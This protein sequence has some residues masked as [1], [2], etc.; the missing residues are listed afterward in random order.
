ME[1]LETHTLLVLKR[2][3]VAADN[4]DSLVIAA[5]ELQLMSSLPR[6][7]NIVHYVDS[8]VRGDE[9]ATSRGNSS[10]FSGHKS[11]Y[12]VS[13]PQDSGGRMIDYDVLME[14]CTGGTVA[15]ELDAFIARGERMPERRVLRRWRDLVSGLAQLHAQAPF[16]VHRDVKLE[17]LLLMPVRRDTLEVAGAI[18]G[19]TDP[20]GSAYV[21]RL[22]DFGSCAIGEVRLDSESAVGLEEANVSLLRRFALQLLYIV[23]ICSS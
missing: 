22:C 18:T 17:N 11:K 15:Q 16:L 7:E 13:A 8:C 10:S 1:D 5:R 4:A 23:L 14:H 20:E 19:A 2:M 21:G 12:S 9:T 6:H 3:R